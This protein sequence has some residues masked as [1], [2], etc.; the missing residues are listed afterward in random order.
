MNV[1]KE[2]TRVK[3]DPAAKK[4]L[5]TTVKRLTRNTYVASLFKFVEFTKMT[6]SQ[7]IDEAI[8][9]MKREPRERRDAAVS[10][11]ISFYNYLKNDYVSRD[12]KRGM[13]D[14]R[15]DSHHGRPVILRQL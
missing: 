10:R 3:A 6:P 15:H 12:G 9:D 5:G 1:S 8:E 14:E 4:W 13:S 2:I 7:L 11:L